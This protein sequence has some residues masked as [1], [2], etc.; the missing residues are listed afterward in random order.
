VIFATETTSTP[1]RDVTAEGLERELAVT[2]LSRLALLRKIAALKA[3]DPTRPKVRAWVLGFPGVLVDHGELDDFNAT[4]SYS[5]VRQYMRAIVVNEALVHAYADKL[6]TVGLNPGRM[7][8]G[9]LVGAVGVG[10]LDRALD[11]ALGLFATTPEVYADKVVRLV[12]M[13]ELR[14]RTGVLFNSAAEEIE[15]SE[16]CAA[17]ENAK[18]LVASMEALIDDA[19]AGKLRLARRWSSRSAAAAA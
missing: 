12:L 9:M 6:Q 13:P 4:R 1:T 14:G 11:W 8:S 7:P 5:P 2:A 18:A 3:K 19:I 15:P 16:W 17:G 10:I